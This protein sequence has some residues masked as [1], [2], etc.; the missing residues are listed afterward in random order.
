MEDTVRVRP[1]V[2]IVVNKWVWSKGYDVC[3]PSRRCEFD[4]RYLLQFGTVAKWLRLGSAKALFSV[5]L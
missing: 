4:S 5:Q 1:P 3:L 2:E